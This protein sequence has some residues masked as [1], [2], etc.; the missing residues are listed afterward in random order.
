M[1]D[2]IIKVYVES[3]KFASRSSNTKPP[4][5]RGTSSIPSSSSKPQKGRIQGYDRRAQLLA[6]AKKLRSPGGKSAKWS[7]AKSMAKDN[8]KWKWPT[9]SLNRITTT[10]SYP[11]L[12]HRTNKQW[13]YEQIA[14]ENYNNDVDELG[15]QQRKT[16]TRKARPKRNS[17]FCEKIK[18]FL[19]QL[20]CFCSC[21]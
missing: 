11:K 1:K 21:K 12:S 5:K 10:S 13:R 2:V 16:T 18:S 15:K 14:T 8:P 20:S 6:Y 9:L 19:K 7:E 4:S 3:S 17:G